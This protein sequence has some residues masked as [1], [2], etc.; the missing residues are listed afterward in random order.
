MP[1]P[2]RQPISS[3]YPRVSTPTQV[4]TALS[5]LVQRS[6][7]GLLRSQLPASTGCLDTMT[8]DRTPA[9]STSVPN[10]A[11]S[12]PR[13]D[14]VTT[15]RKSVKDRKPQRS[16]YVKLQQRLLEDMYN[17]RWHF[18]DSK[19]VDCS[20]ELFNTVDLFSGCG[21]MSLGFE[22]AG[23]QSMLAVE[24]DPDAAA[25]YRMNFPRCHVWNDDVAH[26]SNDHTLELLGGQQVHALLGG[27]PCQGFSVAGKRDP[28]DP[29]NQLFWETIRFADL[30]KPEFVVLENVPGVLTMQQGE[31]ANMIREE[32]HKIG[33]PRMTILILEAADYGVPQYRPRAIFVANRNGLSNPYPR[34]LLAAQNH[35]SIDSAIGDMM[36]LDR[37]PTTSHEWTRHSPS[38]IKRLSEIEPG[39]SLYDSYADAWKRQYSGVPSMTVKE[40]HGGSHVHHKL[41]RTLSAREMARLQSFPDSFSFEGRMKR[42]MFQVGNAVPPLLAHHVARALRTELRTT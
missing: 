34:A 6:P 40:N 23:F 25:T 13:A 21:G 37:D 10:V 35:V 12:A 15:R 32:F 22:Q 4:T 27:F 36:C 7:N 31:V 28:N 39:G 38:M 2:R 18:V 5:L 29:R 24:I 1:S 41:D 8:S 26:L 19:A 33:Y 14:A 9:P 3:T 42:V 17:G 11:G 30:L 16:R 20:S